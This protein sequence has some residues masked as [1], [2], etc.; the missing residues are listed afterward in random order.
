MTQQKNHGIITA[1][2][3]SQP[4]PNSDTKEASLIKSHDAARTTVQDAPKKKKA[5]KPHHGKKVIAVLLCIVLFFE[6]L[7]CFVVFTDIPLIK[8]LREAY[9]GTALS[10]MNHQ[11]L[12]KLFLPSYQ[13]EQMQARIDYGKGAQNN[14]ISN[15]PA[16]SATTD[17]TGVTEPDEPTDV[18]EPPVEQTAEEAFYELFWELNRTSFEDYLQAHPDTLR[19]GWENIYINEAGLYD[20]GTEI[21]TSMGE[22]VL[23]I[24]AKNQVLLVRVQGTGYQGVLAIAKDPA[25]LRCAPSAG[26]GSYGQFLETITENHNGVLA[27][28]GSGFIDPNGSGNGGLIAGYAM[29]EGKS[30][31]THYGGGYKR[32]ELTQDNKM[33]VADAYSDVASDVTDATEFYPALIVDG[34]VLITDDAL[35]GINPRACIGQSERGEILMMVI[36]GRLVDRSMGTGL[37]SCCEI[38]KRHEGYNAINLDGGTTAV[39]WFDGEYVTMC[40]NREIQSRYLPNAWVYGNYD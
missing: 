33:Y 34:Q 7:Y 30:Y 35:W 31:G 10:T 13:V 20:D 32:I 2:C 15:R 17:G 25:Q 11:W 40:S 5:K 37:I 29:S 4:S 38:L 27:M 9:I 36:E 8:N 3:I 28:N 19:N 6:A 18:T 26:I 21:Y 16:P 12:A 24:D 14:I 23:A 39:M 22:Q 1:N